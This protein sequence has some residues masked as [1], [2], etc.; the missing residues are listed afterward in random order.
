MKNRLILLFLLISAATLSQDWVARLNG[1]SNSHDAAYSIDVDASQ[2]VYICGELVNTT[3]GNDFFVT[4]YNSSGA[5]QW[6]VTKNGNNLIDKAF[7]LVVDGS[8]NVYVAGFLRNATTSIDAVIY[9]FNSSGSQQWLITLAGLGG[10]SDQANY[11]TKDA[12]DNLYVCGFYFTDNTT[13]E[14][15]LTLKLSP[16]GS[17][18]WQRTYNSPSSLRD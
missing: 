8:S 7:S 11:I 1:T 14:D 4:K 16:A 17:V 3:T 6:T 9:K 13:D 15:V 10:G 18:L 12:S 2:N 5:H